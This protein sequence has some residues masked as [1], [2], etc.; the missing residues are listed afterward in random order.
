MLR[1]SIGDQITSILRK[2]ASQDGES[3]Q[4]T[5]ARLALDYIEEFRE[6][7]RKAADSNTE[8]RKLRKSLVKKLRRLDMDPHMLAVRWLRLYTKDWWNYI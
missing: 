6:D 1:D 7:W 3:I 8:L 2:D 5:N 4:K